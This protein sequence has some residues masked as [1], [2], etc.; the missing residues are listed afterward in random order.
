LVLV[1]VL[2]LGKVEIL[3]FGETSKG[4]SYDIYR[5]L[6]NIFHLKNK[7][8]KLHVRQNKIISL[9]GETLNTI[10]KHRKNNASCIIQ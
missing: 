9:K 1:L 5:Q 2:R 7:I 6:M 10:G 3:I 8:I 4:Y